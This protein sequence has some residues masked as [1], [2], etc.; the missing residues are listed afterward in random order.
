M[1]NLQT[2][3]V[4]SLDDTLTLKNAFQ[5]LTPEEK[6]FTVYSETPEDKEDWIKLLI[7][8][9][10]TSKSLVSSSFLLS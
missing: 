3:K 7:K 5:I 10:E 9:T 1:L 2:T 8:L 6:S 4:K